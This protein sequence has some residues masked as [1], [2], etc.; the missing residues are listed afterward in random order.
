MFI[1]RLIQALRLFKKESPRKNT[2]H[3]S[4]Q[5]LS[6]LLELAERARKQRERIRDL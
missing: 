2:F 6:S 1:R 5:E 3:L 4:A